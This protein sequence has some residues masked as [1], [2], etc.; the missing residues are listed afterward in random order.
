MHQVYIG[1][2]VVAGYVVGI[3]KMLQPEIA[4]REGLLVEIRVEL[5]ICLVENRKGTLRTGPVIIVNRSRKIFQTDPAV[6]ANLQVRLLFRISR[7]LV[8]Q[9]GFRK[10]SRFGDM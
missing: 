1:A 2:V 4:V 7:K 5:H 3:V 9:A 8:L 10:E 6:V